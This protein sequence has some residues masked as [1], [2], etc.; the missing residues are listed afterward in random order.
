MT[1]I[2]GQKL[3]LPTKKD[4]S[5]FKLRKGMPIGVMVTQEVNVRVFR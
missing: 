2:N 1:L 3:C 5:N 4:I